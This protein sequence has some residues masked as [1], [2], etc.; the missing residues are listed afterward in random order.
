MPVVH[1]RPVP[2]D[3]VS[4][5]GFG[6]LVSSGWWQHTIITVI[7]ITIVQSRRRMPWMA[8]QQMT[9]PLPAQ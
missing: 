1:V 8:Q 5:S 3:A 2:A 9:L 6:H 4:T 7:I